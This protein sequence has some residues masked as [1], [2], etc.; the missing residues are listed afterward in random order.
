MKNFLKKNKVKI[1]GVILIL[2]LIFTLTTKSFGTK[3]ETLNFSSR[4][5]YCKMFEC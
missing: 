2:A 4:K 1:L 5:G 3:Y